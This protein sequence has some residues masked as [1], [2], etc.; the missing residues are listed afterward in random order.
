MGKPG[1][2]SGMGTGDAAGKTHFSF[3]AG[4]IMIACFGKVDGATDAQ[5][6][7]AGDQWLAAPLTKVRIE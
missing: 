4:N 7:F 3:I 1:V 5:Y 2:R 6:F